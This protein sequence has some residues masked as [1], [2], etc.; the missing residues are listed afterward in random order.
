MSSGENRYTF[1]ELVDEKNNALFHEVH[2]K[3]PIQLIDSTNGEWGGVLNKDGK[4]STVECTPSTDPCPCF[5]HELLH[6]KLELGGLLKPKYCQFPKQFQY[7]VAQTMNDLAH[8]R[9]YP[10]FLDLGY[11]PEKFIG[12]AE[13][14]VEEY[15]EKEL[16]H[17]TDLLANN[18]KPVGAQVLRLYFTIHNPHDS[19]TTEK[20]RDHFIAVFGKAFVDGLDAILKDWKESDSNDFSSYV[21]K[22]FGHC[23]HSGWVF[24]KDK[25]HTFS[26]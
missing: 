10:Q 21:A 3:A 22:L 4:S 15:I 14:G 23:G 13:Q 9:M 11:P 17:F 6:I 5:A 8:H 1:N 16:K 18:G 12:N 20:Y 25:D 7:E 2:Q 19:A 24:G 26:S